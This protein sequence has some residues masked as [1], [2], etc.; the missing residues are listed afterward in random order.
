MAEKNFLEIIGP[1]RYLRVWMTKN[2]LET[3]P[4]TLSQ[5]LDQAL[6]LAQTF[7]LSQFEQ[8]THG[9]TI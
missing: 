5:G 7:Q 8:S 9:L 6:V 4:P 2:F 3:G 1:L